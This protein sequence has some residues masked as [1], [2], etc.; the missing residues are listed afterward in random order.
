MVDGEDRAHSELPDMDRLVDEQLD[1]LTTMWEG[2][3][4]TVEPEEAR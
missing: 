4:A 1:Q 3:L 2:V